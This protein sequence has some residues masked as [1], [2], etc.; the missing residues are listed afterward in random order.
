MLLLLLACSR[1]E[2]AES[3]QID[4]MRIL[5]IASEPAE[6][7]PGDTV[8]FSSLIVSPN[9]PVQC[10]AWIG[11]S[12]DSGACGL[13]GVDTAAQDTAALA[14]G[15]L[16]VDPYLPPSWT[17]PDDYLDSLDE[18]AKLEGTTSIITVIALADCE[19]L[20]AGEVTDSQSLLQTGKDDS[21]IAYKRVPVSLAPTP[22]HNPTLAGWTV[23]G[24]T[25]APGAR[26]TLD[27]G[28]TYTLDVTLADG[29]VE[30]YTY[31]TEAGV[32]ETR[33][34]QPYFSW[35][36]QEGSFDQTNTL[37]DV[38]HVKYT[39][40]ASPKLA[41]Q[42]VWV[43]VRDRRGGMGWAELPLHLR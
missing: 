3:W 15:F 11:C 12:G 23:D 39:T 28:Q 14:S 21:E 31:R 22:N 42:S 41:D 5:A 7:R 30:D 37:Y 17:V 8:H 43:V 26:V 2:V 32:D 33:T 25:I 27:P 13:T 18:T 36:S 34:E 38:T 10:S 9:K 35:Y 20:L 29:A 1:T 19:S 6:P 16:G 40:A 4:R 24:V